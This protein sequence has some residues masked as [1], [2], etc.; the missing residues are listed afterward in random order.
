MKTADR[1]VTLQHPRKEFLN[2]E[3]N[4]VGL[5]LGRVR[6]LGGAFWPISA[7]HIDAKGCHVR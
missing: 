3:K 4:W 5:G 6:P 7:S 1:S 2:C